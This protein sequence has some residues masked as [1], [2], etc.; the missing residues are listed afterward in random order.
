MRTGSN[1]TSSP[2]Q[3]SADLASSSTAVRCPLHV[4]PYGLE[5][6]AHE[7]PPRGELGWGTAA[8]TSLSATALAQQSVAG[9][10][11]TTQDQSQ[12]Q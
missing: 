9:F 2:A 11:C 6:S 1:K 8:C 7:A 10:A 3:A 12:Q 4:G 5:L